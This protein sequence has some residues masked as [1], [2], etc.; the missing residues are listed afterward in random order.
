MILASLTNAVFLFIDAAFIARTEI[1]I[2]VLNGPNTT[3]GVRGYRSGMKV[4]DLGEDQKIDGVLFRSFTMK[5]CI[6][7]N[8]TK[9][10]V[11]SG[12]V[13]VYTAIGS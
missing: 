12:G 9:R 7:A 1:D 3:N 13:P 11:V 10:V 2:L 8:P 6:S 5:P 4:L